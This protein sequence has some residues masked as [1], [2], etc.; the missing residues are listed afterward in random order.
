MGKL[1]VRQVLISGLNAAERFNLSPT[2][3]SRWP[4]PCAPMTEVVPD[5]FLHLYN[6]TTAGNCCSSGSQLPLTAA[7]G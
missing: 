7:N 3:V 2:G 5:I 6:S 4:F 1:F